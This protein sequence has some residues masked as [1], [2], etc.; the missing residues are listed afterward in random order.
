MVEAFDI[1]RVNP[2]PARF[3]LKKAEAINAAHMRLLSDRGAHPAGGA[4]PPGAP[5]SSATGRP[6]SDAQ[7]LER[8]CRWSPSG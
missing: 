1:A 4:V 3:D 6:T 7:L 5:G 8:R 2:N